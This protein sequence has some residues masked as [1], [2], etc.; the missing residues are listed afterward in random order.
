MRLVMT[1]IAAA[2]LAGC[3]STFRTSFDAPLSAEVTRGWTVRAV[4]VTIPDNLVVSDADTLVPVADIVWHGDPEGDR[5]Q[6]V[7]AILRDGVMEGAAS[8]SGPRPVILQ[9]VLERFHGVTPRAVRL[10]PSAVH[11]IAYRIRAVDAASGAA[12]T[13]WVEVEADLPARVGAALYADIEAGITEKA[14]IRAHL[15]RVT[16]AWLGQSTDDPRGTFQSLGR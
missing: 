3:A 9:L 16:A 11:N 5:R 2:L 8:L 13:P 1:L 14:R 6:Q 4:D 12:L 15:A 10:A 7:A